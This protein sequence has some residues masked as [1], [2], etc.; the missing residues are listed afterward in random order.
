MNQTQSIVR[1]EYYTITSVMMYLTDATSN[2]FRT[3]ESRL[4][5]QMQRICIDLESTL[6]HFGPP[7]SQ[8]Y[9]LNLSI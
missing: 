5:N 1:F 9:P 3:R 7:I 6:Y 8:E 4:F 2:S